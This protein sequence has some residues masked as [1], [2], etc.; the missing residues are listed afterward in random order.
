LAAALSTTHLLYIFPHESMSSLN[1]RWLD[2][3]ERDATVR[4]RKDQS[5]DAPGVLY[6]LLLSQV[7][8]RPALIGTVVIAEPRVQIPNEGGE[9]I[10]LPFL[11]WPQ[12]LMAA[13]VFQD[14]DPDTV[15]VIP[16]A[17]VAEDFGPQRR[18]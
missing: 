15:W 9:P 11:P 4:T 17:V 3:V 7:L 2:W 10:I 12:P 18:G 16:R 14:G 6:E 8:L 5:Q 13:A 1:A